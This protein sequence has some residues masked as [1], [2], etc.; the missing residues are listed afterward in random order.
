MGGEAARG[1]AAHGVVDAV[2]PAHAAG[3]EAERAADGEHEVDHPYP[4]GTGAEARVESGAD[5]SCGFGCEH[6]DGTADERGKNG[7]GEE[8]DAQAAYPLRHAAPEEQA[9]GQ[10]VYVVNDGGTGGGE[11]RHGFKVG[12]GESGYVA[13]DDEGKRAEEAEDDPRE[14]HDEVGVASAHVVV[15]VSAEKAEHDAR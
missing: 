11:A 5:G 14:R 8:D 1:R 7:R 13:T 10:F 15:G 2:E 9:V 6:F 12:V 3:H 4:L